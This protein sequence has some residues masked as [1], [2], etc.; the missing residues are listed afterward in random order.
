MN[1]SEENRQ[2]AGE[3]HI[4]SPA[5]AVTAGYLLLVLLWILVVD[6]WWGHRAGASALENVNMVLVWGLVGLSTAVVYFGVRAAGREG[7]AVPPIARQSADGVPGLILR[8]DAGG[9]LQSWN[10]EAAARLAL[11]GTWRGRSLV[12]SAADAEAP[13]LRNALQAA[14]QKGAATLE[15]RLRTA[16]GVSAPFLV[17]LR[18]E[19]AGKGLVLTALDIGAVSHSRRQLATRERQ[20]RQMVETVPQLVAV[21]VG[22]QIAYVNPAGA[23]LL[24][25]QD[26][27]E[28]VGRAWAELHRDPTP[29]KPAML[30]RVDGTTFE[31]E[32]QE[33]PIIHDDR[34]ATLVEAR[35]IT[36]ASRAL[37]A[38]RESERR[39][40]TVLGVVDDA[41][42]L[43]DDRGVIHA[44]NQAA[45]RLFGLP[46]H[47]AI[48]Q[49][50]DSL[51]PE[52]HAAA[53][54][55]LPGTPSLDIEGCAVDGRVFPM[56][57]S[58][59][60]VRNGA[61]RLFLCLAH[62]LSSERES[63][64][65]LDIAETV[66]EATSEGV[67]VTDAQGIVL[68]VN[69]AFCR[70]SGYERAEVIGEDSALLKAGIRGGED[71]PLW[72]EVQ[73]RGEW[74]G[75]MWNRRKDGE[76]YPEWLTLKA[77][78]DENG[79][80]VRLVAVFSDISRHK[81]A[82]ET[83]K[84]LTYYDAVTRLPNRY[85]FHD[86]LSQ[87]LE[88]AQRSGT[89][90]AAVMVSLDRFRTINETLGH[91]VGD[92]LLRAISDRLVEAVRA[93][94]TVARLRG[95]TFCCILGELHRSRD[96]TPVVNRILEAFASSFVVSGHELFV[97]V[98]VGISVY[99]L[100]GV[101]LDDL[102]NKAE[103][104][105]N[106]SKTT[107][108][109]SYQFYTPEMHA[110]SVERLRLE[111]D[112]RKA[113]NNDQLVLH[114]QPKISAVDGR[115][116]GAEAL[117][118]WQHPEY[119]MIS[120]GRF[121]PIAEETG[122]IETIGNW[123]LR[124]TCRQIR[125]WQ[126]ADLAVVPVGVN[127]SANQFRRAEL[128]DMVTS[129]LADY[130]VGPHLLEAELT[131]SA[132]M[133]NADVA[134]R[135]L[136]GLHDAGVTLA[137]DDFGTGYS[138]LSYLRR[139]PLD[140]LKIDRS[141]VQDLG[142]SEAGEEIVS[143]IIAMAHSLSLKVVAEGV[144]TAEQLEQLGRL[145][146]DEIQGFLFSRPVPAA[147]F[148]EILRNGGFPMPASPRKAAAGS[149]RKTNARRRASASQG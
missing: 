56:R 6:E 125:A 66:M 43:A 93:P 140:R 57:V 82:E 20:F 37:A 105:M 115:L 103:K 92:T 68:W 29:Q 119:G 22:D 42:I 50:L 84:H 47:E 35:D 15:V 67:M 1:M 23:L 118:R 65:R 63:A 98:R 87:S 142:T 116:V 77:V 38:L 148:E 113:A 145:N 134:V 21:V 41:I 111:T 117:V 14:L 46:Q 85:L 132:V 3:R 121:I 146:C 94:D 10:T 7:R 33:M 48:G 95:D 24:G 107:G 54:R 34:V 73:A 108:E 75:E 86:R 126:D 129:I 12:E 120:P 71:A 59:H 96:A 130:G 110:D 139:F 141:F 88:R 39:L 106:R 138:S 90:V 124:E 60:E 45:E 44:F 89:L 32:I 147:D 101:D 30:R 91:N 137:I 8:T 143:A 11:D 25:A 79:E 19:D 9:R 97:T 133:Q 2:G 74:A 102:I 61:R 17:D 149:K 36:E 55:N 83:I 122:L 64:M 128:V 99:P 136:E 114:Y 49:P 28:V 81:R 58:I 51:A 80:P 76:I 131:E 40:R 100:D 53:L 4:L 104:A 31:A 52:R 70:I 62:D 109:N 16:D 127:F 78:R 72:S 18:R 135:R 112:L 27:E 26:A 13:A 5:V 144:E 69:S 123:V